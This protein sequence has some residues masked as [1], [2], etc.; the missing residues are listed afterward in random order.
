VL[1]P[2]T[3]KEFRTIC[4]RITGVQKKLREANDGVGALTSAVNA[5][6]ATIPELIIDTDVIECVARHLKVREGAVAALEEGGD[7][8]EPPDRMAA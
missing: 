4:L 7:E 2:K 1:K 8:P 5:S 3:Q 6:A